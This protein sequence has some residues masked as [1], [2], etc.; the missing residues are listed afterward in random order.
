MSW[1]YAIVMPDGSR[2]QLSPEEAQPGREYTYPISDGIYATLYNDLRE[3]YQAPLLTSDGTDVHRVWLYRYDTMDPNGIY[4]IVWESVDGMRGSTSDGANTLE[5][6]V[7]VQS[8][9][10]SGPVTVG[11]GPVSVP[12]RPATLPSASGSATA[13]SS[14]IG[15]GTILA[16]IALLGVGGL[17][18]WGGIK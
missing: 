13:A 8:A 7:E 2:Y 1:R 18:L 3:K 16:G 4:P 5:R 14:G 11:G 9:T 12:A 6:S 15:A 17:L 10:P